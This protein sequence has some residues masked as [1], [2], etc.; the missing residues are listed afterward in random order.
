MQH[1]WYHFQVGEFTTH[2]RTYFAGWIGMFT[3]GT[4]WILTHG[5]LILSSADGCKTLGG[6]EGS[7]RRPSKSA[8]VQV[9]EAPDKLRST[10]ALYFF[11]E[12]PKGE[13]PKWNRGKTSMCRCVFLCFCLCLC[14]F[15]SLRGSF[16]EV[17]FIIFVLGKNKGKQA[18][19]N[20][21]LP[22]LLR[23]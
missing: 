3:G 8:H 7:P 1:Q 16:F 11:E 22:N 4:I 5:Q 14:I 15:A 13:G 10:F 6:F 20:V 19:L 23:K 21:C 9:G 17:V 18:I 2:F 12:E